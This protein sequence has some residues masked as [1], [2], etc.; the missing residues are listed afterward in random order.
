MLAG[1]SVA[2]R[3]VLELAALVRN[4]GFD[5]VA[6]KLETAYD[7]ETIVLALT[8]P[9]AKRLSGRSTIRPTASPSS[10]GCCPASTS[11]GCARGSSRRSLT[12]PSG[13]SACRS[14]SGFEAR[15]VL[16][17]PCARKQGRP[18]TR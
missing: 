4:A 12:P 8:V 5:D 10:A 7:R 17:A 9:S 6:Q 14:S 1:L 15:G 11:G 18:G 16:R 2:D 13:N 3:N